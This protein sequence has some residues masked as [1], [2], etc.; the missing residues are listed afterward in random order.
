MKGILFCSQKM[1]EQLTNQS[2]ALERDAL[3]TKTVSI[4]IV[5]LC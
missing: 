3:Y 4:A 5:E 2:P 1:Q